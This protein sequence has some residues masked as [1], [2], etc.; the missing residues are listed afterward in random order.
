MQGGF[1]FQVNNTCV[2]VDNERGLIISSLCPNKLDC[3]TFQTF[4]F[5]DVHLLTEGGAGRKLGVPSVIQT[6]K[7]LLLIPI[8]LSPGIIWT[9]VW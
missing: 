3:R 1:S 7:G 4:A 5:G 6:G 2:C 8:A 9:Y